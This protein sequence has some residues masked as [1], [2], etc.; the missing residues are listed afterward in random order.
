MSC[1]QD[2]IHFTLLHIKNNDL[3]ELKIRK[4][5]SL[6]T[7]K[8]NSKEF[9]FTIVQLY[10]NILLLSNELYLLKDKMSSY[11]L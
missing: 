10:S 7:S 3:L 1:L 8:N 9:H 11:L 5:L 6:K 2:N 4:G